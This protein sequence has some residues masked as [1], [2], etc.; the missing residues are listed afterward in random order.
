MLVA[1][2]TTW[3]LVSTSPSELKI[4]PVPAACAPWYF[5]TVFTSTT[6]TCCA[7]VAVVP[8]PP[9]ELPPNGLLPLPPNG[10]LPLPPNGLLPLPPNGSPLPPNGSVDPEPFD[11]E[12]ADP[13]AP[14][15][16]DPGLD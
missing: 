2:S 8:L 15:P 13:D 7:V 10:L 3:L 16:L 14:D 12:P 4:M 5:K 11:P 9:D 6:P 1:P